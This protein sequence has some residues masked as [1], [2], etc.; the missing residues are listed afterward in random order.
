MC[1]SPIVIKA[2]V[3]G[4]HTRTF[5]VPCGK[6][7]ECLKT[8]QND[9]MVR[10]YEELLQAGSGCFLT[11]TYSNDTVP[12]LERDGKKYYTVYKPDVKDWLKRFRT[13]YE[14]ETGKTGVRFFLCSEYGPRTHRPHYHCLFFGLSKKD[15]H[16]AIE[17]WTARFGFVLA[18][19]IDPSPGSF[20]CSARYVS[21]YSC[22]GILEDPFR[23]QIR[24]KQTFSEFLKGT[25]FELCPAHALLPYFFLLS[26]SF[27]GANYTRLLYPW[28]YQDFRTCVFGRGA[29]AEVCCD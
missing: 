24:T 11:L 3:S 19:D 18:K 7:I 21:K 5:T 16:S 28:R 15:L 25:R 26:N 27:T 23:I 1:L 14:R 12:Y 29:E 13:N 17:D 4:G 10:I 20:E 22:K 6:C 8:K 9:Y 2:D